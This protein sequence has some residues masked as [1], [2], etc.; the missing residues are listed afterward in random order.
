MVGV[1]YGKGRFVE[2]GL[3]LAKLCVSRLDI[4]QVFAM[5]ESANLPRGHNRC[6]SQA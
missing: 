3:F 5:K 4:R 6:N 2:K 1:R